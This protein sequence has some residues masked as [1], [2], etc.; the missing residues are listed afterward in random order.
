MLAGL[1][2]AKTGLAKNMVRAHGCARRQSENAFF[3]KKAIMTVKK[4]GMRTSMFKTLK[5]CALFFKNKQ[6]AWE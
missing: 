2:F 3:Q 6:T 5:G 1:R 4:H